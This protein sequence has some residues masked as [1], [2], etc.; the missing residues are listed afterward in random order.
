MNIGP[1][2]LMGSMSSLLS[3]MVNEPAIA[4]MSAIGINLPRRITIAVE[5]FQNGVFAEVPK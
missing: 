3:F 1:C 2:V 4:S 5:M